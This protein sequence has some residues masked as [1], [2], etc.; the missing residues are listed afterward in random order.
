MAGSS[1]VVITVIAL[2]RRDHSEYIMPSVAFIVG[3]H[4]FGLARAM[5]GGGERVFVWIG[6]L[7]C[8]SAA[9]IIFAIARSLLS[10]TQSMAVTGFSCAII[11]WAAAVS[12]LI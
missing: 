4:F 2:R 7:I 5:T 10:S 11:L 1:R 12:T 9:V 6:G 3:A 8:I